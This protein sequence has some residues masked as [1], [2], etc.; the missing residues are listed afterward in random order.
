MELAGTVKSNSHPVSGSGPSGTH[1]YASVDPDGD[2]GLRKFLH[3]MDSFSGYDVLVKQRKSTRGNVRCASCKRDIA[4][5]PHCKERLQRTIE[6]AID[7]AIITNMI[8]MA[9]DNIYDVALIGSNDADIAPAIEFI[10]QRLGKH[11]CHLWFPGKGDTMRNTCWDHLSMKDILH[12][13]G[14]LPLPPKN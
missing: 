10:Q 2:A 4:T 3:A 5:C 13:L 1:V 7:S 9:H 6:K 12:D 8:Q 11:V 14:L